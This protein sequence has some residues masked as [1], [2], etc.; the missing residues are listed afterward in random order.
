MQKYT[1]NAAFTELAEFDHFAKP[2]DFV[3]ICEWYNGEGI[4]ITISARD[5]NKS[6]SLTFGEFD[7]IKKLMKEF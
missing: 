4:D 2:S 1:R 7:A 5:E 3:E 6:I